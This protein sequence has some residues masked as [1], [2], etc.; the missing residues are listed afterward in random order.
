M[1]VCFYI[2]DTYEDVDKEEYPLITTEQFKKHVMKEEKEIIG[3]NFKDNR[4]AQAANLL[5]N[6]SIHWVWGSDD[7]D[8][9]FSIGTTAQSM[10]EEY[11][12]LTKWC[13]PVYKEDEIP[14]VLSYS[15]VI[16]GEN[17]IPNNVIRAKATIRINKTMFIS[18][19][20]CSLLPWERYSEN[21]GTNAALA[22]PSPTSSLRKRPGSS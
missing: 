15:G 1:K 13:D 8:A 17:I 7:V 20:S 10:L 14:K 9:D 2:N 11:D 21:T 5:L 18:F 6:Y 19:H 3:Y 22:G 12:L 4:Y 16:K